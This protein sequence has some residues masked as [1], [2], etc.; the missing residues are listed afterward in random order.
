MKKFLQVLINTLIA[1]VTTSFLWFGLTF[2]AYLETQSVVATAVVG[3][4]YMLFV[5]ISS[6]FFGTL[7]D[8]HHKKTI[9]VVSAVITLATYAFAGLIYLFSPQELITNL[10]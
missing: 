9:M 3:G 8:K 5:S 10:L 2:W 6:L 1:N 4:I 7:V